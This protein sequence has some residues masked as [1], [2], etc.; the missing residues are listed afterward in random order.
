[1]AGC[2]AKVASDQAIGAAGG[3]CY[4]DGRCDSGLVCSDRRCVDPLA[5]LCTGVGCSGHGTCVLDGELPRCDCEPGYHSAGTTCLANVAARLAWSPPRTRAD[6]MPL[7]DLAGYWLHYGT[8]PRTTPGFSGYELADE[9]GTPSCGP[10]DHGVTTCT[11]ILESLP[12]GVWYF[13]VT[14]Y[15]ALGNLSELSNEVTREVP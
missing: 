11:Y 10:D 9:I 14:S 3:A 1:V 5:N 8:R 7:A 6:G 12:A 2:P 4:A 13:A 15:D